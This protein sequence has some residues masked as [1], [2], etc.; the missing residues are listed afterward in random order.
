M[1]T[2][3]A[4]GARSVAIASDADASA[5]HVREADEVV[6]IGGAEPKDSYLRVD[7]V[8]DAARRTGAKAVHPGYGFLSERADLARACEEAGIA[9]VGPPAAMLEATNDKL[10]VKRTVAAAGVPVIAGPLEPVAEGDAALRAA[11]KATGFPML[12]KAV[13]GGGGR[14]MR[15]VERAEDLAS[16]AESARREAGGAFGD[17]RLYAEA[18]LSG[19]RHVE[20]QVLVD[21]RGEVLVLGE[22]DC[23]LQRRHQKVIEETPA[24]K[25]PDAARRALHDAAA[26]AA[27]ALRYRNAG[28]VEFLVGP[29]GRPAFLEVNR[30]L[31]VE[32][33]VTEAVLGI[34]LVAWQLRVA[35]GE[36]LPPAGTWSP[37]G[38][39]IEARVTAEDPAAGFLPSVGRLVDVRWPSGPGIRVDAGFHAG[40]EVSP[41]YDSLLAKVIAHAETREQAIARL[42]RALEET[43]VLGV[44][45]N[46]AFL[47]RCLASETFRSGAATVDW[48]DHGAGRALAADEDVPADALLAAA[49]AELLGVGKAP[50]GGARAPEG[51]GVPASA[52]DTLGGWRLLDREARS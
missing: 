12:L 51:G 40:D 22:R 27:K 41:Y 20:V 25:L 50:R 38:H 26:K 9:F 14:G 29:D 23:S 32:H 31:Q 43:A 44:R 39:A 4:L 28:T 47:R 2:L 10:G 52:W 45:S 5:A 35:A 34:D 46:V 19:A 8:V 1:R 24:A 36:S 17:V 6:R 49:A 16:A 21:A 30:R 48:L 3:R 37:R 18:L 13:G 15:R 7:A 33:P 11:A 42:D